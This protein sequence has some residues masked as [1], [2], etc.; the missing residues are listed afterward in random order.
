MFIR[1]FEYLIAL[2]KER[3]FGR[4]AEK[5]F[6]SQPSLSTALN[7]LEDE[8]GV[9]IILRDHKFIGFTNEGKKVVEWSK[10]ILTNQKGL[11]DDII[12]MKDN[13]VGLL[14]IGVIPMSSPVLPM[15]SEILNNHLPS[16]KIN[17]E[18]LGSDNLQKKLDNYEIDAAI[19]YIEDI[20]KKKYENQKLYNENLSLMFGNNLLSDKIISITWKEA[21]KMPLCLLSKFMKEREN[22]DKAFKE[23]NSIPSPKL[24]CNSI[25]QLAFHVMSQNIATIVPS[26][27]S[28]KN[29]AF[30]N[31]REI[32]LIEPIVRKPVGLVWKKAE[33]PFPMTKALSI[34]L[35]QN[36]EKFDE[37]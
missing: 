2:E 8:L 27:F 19:T 33:P 6:V 37:I 13:L 22:M 26:G 11:I 23:S 9:K 21:S 31:T 29:N 14:R 30:P 4:A 7:Q 3:H 5:C 24:E 28:T 17:I 1:Q 35:N 32:P 10:I 36:L 20:D 16:I 18:F 15:V 12:L 34:L 25:F